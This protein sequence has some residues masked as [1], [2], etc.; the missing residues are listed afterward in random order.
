MP[1]NIQQGQYAQ[2]LNSAQAASYAAIAAKDHAVDSPIGKKMAELCE[3][4]VDLALLDLQDQKVVETD[5][6]LP[7]RSDADTVQ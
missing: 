6:P 7:E 1:L 5:E 4:L 3:R 2:G